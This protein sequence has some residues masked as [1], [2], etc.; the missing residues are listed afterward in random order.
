M[1]LENTG[2]GTAIGCMNL[3]F[4]LFSHFF[5]KVEILFDVLTP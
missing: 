5:C 4:V 3:D 1:E 2:S